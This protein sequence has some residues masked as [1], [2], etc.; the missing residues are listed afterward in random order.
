MAKRGKLSKIEEF[1]ILNNRSKSV[2]ELANDLDRT[3]ASV[4]KVL[5][6]NPAEEQQER[7]DG[8]AEVHPVP[9]GQAGKLMGRKERNGQHVATVMTPAAS[10]A[11]DDF[12]KQAVPTSRYIN[13]N[14]VHRPKG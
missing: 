4:Q 5:D 12:R 7:Q 6:A 3:E 8:I 1:Y 14:T 10:E 9:E 2:Q 13:E 11:A